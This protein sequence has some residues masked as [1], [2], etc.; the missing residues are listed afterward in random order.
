MFFYF[1]QGLE[2]IWTFSEGSR[3]FRAYDQSLVAGFD[4][5][6]GG[7]P[8]CEECMWGIGIVV[9]NWIIQDNDDPTFAGSLITAMRQTCR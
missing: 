9:E 2:L 3:K 6:T 8:L 5:V 1:F 7:G 4:L